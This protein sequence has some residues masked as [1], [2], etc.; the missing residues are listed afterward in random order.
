MK[1][2][3]CI[4]AMGRS[5]PQ[6]QHAANACSEPSS[7]AMTPWRILLPNSMITDLFGMMKRRGSEYRLL[8][9]IWTPD[10]R[11]KDAL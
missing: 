2:W 11:D 8:V 4:V 9:I 10:R 7:L 1:T 6:W 3:Q 5:A